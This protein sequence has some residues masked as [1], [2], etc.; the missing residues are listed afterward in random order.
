MAMVTDYLFQLIAKQVDDRGLVVGWW[1]LRVIFIFSACSYSLNLLRSPAESP[2]IAHEEGRKAGMP[3]RSNDSLG[4]DV[5]LAKFS[6]KPCCL[7]TA[8]SW[9][10]TIAK[11]TRPEPPV[12][13]DR[14]SDDLLSQGFVFQ[15]HFSSLLLSWFPDLTS[16]IGVP[17]FTGAN[18]GSK[19]H[20]DRWN[21]RLPFV[22]IPNESKSILP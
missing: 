3:S 22:Q 11:W 4:L 12:Q 5:V 17:V 7:A 14:R 1:K 21:V 15:G 13:L 16:R 9:E 2:P 20:L 8:F 6:S 10:R 19:I 18:D